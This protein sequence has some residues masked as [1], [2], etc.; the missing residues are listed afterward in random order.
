VK[1]VARKGDPVPFPV[2][3]TGV[4]WKQF[5][6]YWG[7]G[8]IGI[9]QVLFLARMQGPGVTTLNDEALWLLQ[10][11]GSYLLLLRE[12]DTA[13][14]CGTGAIGTIQRVVANPFSGHYAVLASLTNTSATTN[15]ALFTGNTDVVLAQ[16]PLRRAFLKLRKGT[17][18]DIG[19]GAATTLKSLSLPASAFDATGAGAK[20]L[21]Q[22]I[23]ATGQMVL[24]VTFNDLAVEL[25]R[26]TP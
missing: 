25:M 23:N 3:V 5:L 16:A 8:N 19:F 1:L 18:Y 14:D 22:P 11:D 12:G 4:V 21:G 13:P 2:P 26:G 10:E 6:N 9:G 24:K 20:G 7:M 15:Q 17:L